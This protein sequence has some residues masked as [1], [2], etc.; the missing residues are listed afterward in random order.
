MPILHS[1]RFVL[2]DRIG[3]VRGNY[4]GLAADGRRDLIRDLKKVLPLHAKNGE[5]YFVGIFLVGAYQEILGDMHNLFGNTNTVHISLGAAGQYH[6]D[7]VISGETVRHR[8][9]R[10]CA[11]DRMARVLIET[12]GD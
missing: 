7:E 9:D 8:R 12:A 2:V 10:M 11:D 5:D 6:I 4:D 1:S 3:R